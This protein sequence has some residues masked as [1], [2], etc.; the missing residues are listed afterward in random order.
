M[1]EPR[2]IWAY[3]PLLTGKVLRN[4]SQRKGLKLSERM[5]GN[6]CRSV[7]TVGR[8]FQRTQ[9]SALIVAKVYLTALGVNSH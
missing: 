5:Y 4:V 2:T 1:E 3:R 6:R 9:A 7:L 8:V